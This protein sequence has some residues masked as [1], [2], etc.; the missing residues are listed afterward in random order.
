MLNRVFATVGL[1]V[2]IH[3]VAI[4]Q[5]A[6]M[7]SLRPDKV[8]FLALFKELIETNTTGALGCLRDSSI[9]R[10]WQRNS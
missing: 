4:S 2:A 6:P 9:R 8:A 5:E 1:A 10:I 3:A 7:T